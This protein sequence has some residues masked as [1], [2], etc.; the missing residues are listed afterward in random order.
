MSWAQSRRILRILSRRKLTEN[1][2]YKARHDYARGLLSIAELSDLFGVDGQSMANCVYGR[3]YRDL[4]L[5]WFSSTAGT[6]KRRA[7]PPSTGA[8]QEHLSPAEFVRRVVVVAR[9]IAASMSFLRASTLSALAGSG[10]WRQMSDQMAWLL[11]V[12]IVVMK[13]PKNYRRPF[14]EWITTRAKSLYAERAIEFL[15]LEFC[16]RG[17]R[18]RERGLIAA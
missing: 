2:V 15:Y 5:V 14:D 6:A 12:E 13:L 3:T 18:P 17:I 16:R 4:P 10:E 8:R 9:R 7:H 11:T 1:Q